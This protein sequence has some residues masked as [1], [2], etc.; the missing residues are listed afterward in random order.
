MDCKEVV[1]SKWVKAELLALQ[2]LDTSDS[3][4]RSIQTKV[5]LESNKKSIWA[6]TTTTRLTVSQEPLSSAIKKLLKHYNSPLNAAV[7]S[8]RDPLSD[9][10]RLDVRKLLARPAAGEQSAKVLG[11]T[12]IIMVTEYIVMNILKYILKYCNNI[13]YEIKQKVHQWQIGRSR[14]SKWGLGIL[15]PVVGRSFAVPACSEG[16]PV[17]GICGHCDMLESIGM[18]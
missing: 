1:G 16:V 13:L 8:L 18:D 4:K 12:H 6:S 7:L 2:N 3:S 11:A 14:D 10:F 5:S 9:R 17:I 15:F